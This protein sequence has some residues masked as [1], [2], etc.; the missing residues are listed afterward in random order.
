MKHWVFGLSA[1]LM[2]TGLLAFAL[3]ACSVKIDESAI[4]DGGADAFA[5]AVVNCTADKD[6]S[7]SDSCVTGKCDPGTQA[8]KFEVCPTG[9][10]C[11]AI[12]CTTANRCG[13]V[14]PFGFNAGSFTI[15]EG[16]ACSSCV[17]AVFPY[18]FVVS[19]LRVHAFRVSDPTDTT[20]PELPI[21]DLGFTPKTVVTQ[22]RRI[23]FVGGPT[24][25]SSQPYKL[26]V[27]WVDAPADVGVTSLRA[28]I[29]TL[30]F[31]SP[32]FR[33]DGVIAG[34]DNQL[35][36]LHR[37]Q[38]YEMNMGVVRDQELLMNITSE[39]DPGMLN[40]I[41]PKAY[42][43]N[44]HSV[45]FSNGRL[46]VYRNEK[47]VGTFNFGQNPGTPEA[48]TSA[49]TPLPGM[50]TVGAVSSF[51]QSADGTVYWASTLRLPPMPNQQQ[52][53][54]GVRLAVPLSAGGGAFNLGSKVDLETY[55]GNGFPENNGDGNPYAGPLVSMGTGALLAL[56]AARE[57]SGQT[58]IQVVTNNN[59]ALALAPGKR[60]VVKQRVDQV[61]AAG[62][63]GFGYVVTPDTADS[64]TVHTFSPGCQ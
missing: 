64:M 48:A 62:T 4:Y 54:S 44:G 8:C 19:N 25:A 39:L 51:G 26:Q 13:R 56:A 1:V 61:A 50:G 15:P 43:A 9:D 40:F 22:G 23:Y 38:S 16:L 46:V 32:D 53:L 41:L 31:P 52:M 57:N 42:P 2:G 14:S 18:V 49:D 6:C 60:L 3:G 36:A 63:D 27:A 33:Y 11:S 7:S 5:P 37:V 10:Q 35:F 34:G 47:N 12:S 28:H 29:V 58:S 24:G 20:P 45:S 55:A 30:P 21:T 17:G 59:G